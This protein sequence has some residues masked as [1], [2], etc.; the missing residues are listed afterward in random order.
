MRTR[1]RR[2]HGAAERSAAGAAAEAA[3]QDQWRW[4]PEPL[5]LHVHA[6]PLDY[7]ATTPLDP[8]VLE[9]ML[10]WL[11]VHFGNASSRH[12][13]GRAA[14]RAIDEA[15]Q[16]VADALGAHPTEIIFTSGGSKPTTFP[17]R[18]VRLSQAGAAG[19][20]GGRTPVHRQAGGATGAAGWQLDPACR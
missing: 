18:R 15:R 9:A 1:P 16:Q 5:I 8:A 4:L 20:V 11:S 7:N 14:R 10:P 6:G 17:E 3:R 12:E 2:R 19:G 13:Y